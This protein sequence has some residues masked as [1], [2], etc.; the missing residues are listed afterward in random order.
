MSSCQVSASVRV[1]VSFQS[2][3]LSASPRPS[4]TKSEDGQPGPEDDVGDGRV[5][6]KV[7]VVQTSPDNE[8]LRA[9]H[10]HRSSPSPPPPPSSRSLVVLHQKLVLAKKRSTWRF[11][12]IFCFLCFILLLHR[13]TASPSVFASF[14]DVLYVL[15]F[16]TC[17]LLFFNVEINRI[18]K[19]QLRFPVPASSCT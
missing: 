19:N 5:V 4:S 9:S 14:H 2:L 7:S 3:P 10:G 18:L 1:A 17:E 13:G 16:V 12:L 15:F 6:S 11:N 8:W